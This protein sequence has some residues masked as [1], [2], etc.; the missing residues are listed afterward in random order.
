M[1][2]F[3]ITSISRLFYAQS[4]V[5]FSIPKEL[6]HQSDVNWG[7]ELEQTILTEKTNS[8]K[9]W[10]KFISPISGISIIYY[11]L[12]FSFRFGLFQF[13]T[14][15]CTCYSH[16][17]KKKCNVPMTGPR[18]HQSMLGRLVVQYGS[19]ITHCLHSVWPGFNSQPWRSI[20]KD[21]PLAYY[22]LLALPV[23][24][25]PAWQKRAQSPFKGTTQPVDIE[26]E[27]LHPTT[28]RQQTIK[29]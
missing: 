16:S 25:D 11:K 8:K 17:R 29:E 9:Y 27:D 18:S 13:R 21:F 22:T 14:S 12:L 5:S 2:V 19:T 15:M 1:L 7:S 10:F 28:N 4:G 26:Q 6:S 23:I 24:P 20:S 3:L